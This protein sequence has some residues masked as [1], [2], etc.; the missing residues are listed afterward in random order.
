MF[1]YYTL[2]L[3]LM[4]KFILRLIVVPKIKHKKNIVQVFAKFF[5][6]CNWN[7]KFNFD[8]FVYGRIIVGL[9]LIQEKI[10]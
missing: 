1:R 3:F 7:T 4:K 10:G 2:Q 8:Y 5:L 9:T 6:K